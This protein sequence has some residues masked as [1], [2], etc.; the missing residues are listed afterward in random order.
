MMISNNNLLD[1]AFIKNVTMIRLITKTKF[2]QIIQYE[3]YLI[4]KQIY[5]AVYFGLKPNK[6]LIKT[7]ALAHKLYPEPFTKH[8]VPLYSMFSVDCTLNL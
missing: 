6:S 2:K 8:H 5:D 1:L 4:Q 3:L 7:N